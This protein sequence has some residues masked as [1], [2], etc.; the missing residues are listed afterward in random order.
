MKIRAENPQCKSKS[1]WDQITLV[2]MTVIRK[3]RNVGEDVEKSTSYTLLMGIYV[4]AASLE[5]PQEIKDWTDLWSAFPLLDIY[6]KKMKT[7][8]RK[9]TCTP[10]SLATLVTVAKIWKHSCPLMDEWLKKMRDT[11]T[12]PETLFSHKKGEFS[13]CSNMD[14]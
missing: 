8:T 3:T 14:G 7:L 6:P 4:G 12:D 13:H 2:R 9:D 5:V 10:T 11:C 1:Q